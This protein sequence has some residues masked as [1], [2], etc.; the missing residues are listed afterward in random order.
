LPK[1]AEIVAEHTDPEVPE[2]SYLVSQSSKKVLNYAY[3]CPSSNLTHRREVCPS[4]K[5][6]KFRPYHPVVRLLVDTLSRVRVR[7]DAG[8]TLWEASRLVL[9]AYQSA[10]FTRR[11]SSH[12]RSR[13][14]SREMLAQALQRAQHIVQFARPNQTCPLPSWPTKAIAL[15]RRVIERR[16]QVP[17][18]G[19]EAKRVTAICESPILF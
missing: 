7:E 9:Y 1:D 15:L 12:T 2:M 18:A 3:D 10:T 16:A 6:V 13:P 11:V 19:A 4:S 14:S 5:L 8:D 17:G